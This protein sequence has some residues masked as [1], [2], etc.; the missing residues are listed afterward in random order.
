M[1]RTHASSKS[2][3]RELPVCGDTKASEYEWLLVGLLYRSRSIV[4]EKNIPRK[5]A[6]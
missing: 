6:I 5:H 3:L 2:L 4:L 1:P